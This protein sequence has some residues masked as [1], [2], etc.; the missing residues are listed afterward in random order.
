VLLSGGLLGLRDC[1]NPVKF[2]FSIRDDIHHSFPVRVAWTS[3]SW[4]VPQDML[5]FPRHRTSS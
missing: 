1:T 2:G 3:S 5:S 4:L